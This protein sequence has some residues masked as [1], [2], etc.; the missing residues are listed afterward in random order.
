MAEP[1]IKELQGERNRLW[2]EARLK[3]LPV[4]TPIRDRI[5]EL[6]ALIRDRKAASDKR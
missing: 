2:A 1:S 6:D 3:G 5:A 4:G